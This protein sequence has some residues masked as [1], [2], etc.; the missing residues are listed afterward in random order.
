MWVLMN[1]LCKPSLGAPGLV[2]KILQAKMS[3]KWAI[4]NQYILVI[5]NIDENHFVIFEH[6]I[7]CLSLGYVCLPQLEYHFL[8]FLG[9]FFLLVF[10]SFFLILLWLSTFELL[11]ALYSKFKRLKISG[12]A[13]A[14]L[15]LGEPGWG[16]PP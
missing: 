1:A 16:N 11:N 13:S 2:T 12:R 8:S 15:K 14:R 4:L 5:T 10:S 7:N 6:A 9:G 3:Q